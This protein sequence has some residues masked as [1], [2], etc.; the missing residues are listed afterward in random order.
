VVIASRAQFMSVGDSG[1]LKSPSRTDPFGRMD[2]VSELTIEK[3]T[4]NE[5]TCRS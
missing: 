5:L 1:G 4:P 2:S 3:L